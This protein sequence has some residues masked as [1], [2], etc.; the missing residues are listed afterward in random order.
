MEQEVQGRKQ[1]RSLERRGK[2]HPYQLQ[3]GRVP[4]AH[5]LQAPV[6]VEDGVVEVQAG[7]EAGMV[8]KHLFVVYLATG[9]I[10]PPRRELFMVTGCRTC[11][12]S[13]T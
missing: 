7:V 8:G 12:R 3:A 13:R 5:L 2:V 6:H 4:H 1:P 11:S 10:V 9:A